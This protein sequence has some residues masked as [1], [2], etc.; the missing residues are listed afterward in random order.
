MEASIG[1][2][3]WGYIWRLIVWALL[4][5]FVFGFIFSFILSA[6]SRI[7]FYSSPESII[8]YYKKDLIGMLIIS[9]I[10]TVIACKFATSG[11]QKKF[12][13][14]SDNA[15]QVFKRIV[16][17][18]IIFTVIYIIY[19]LTNI[20]NIKKSIESLNS[21]SI[22]TQLLESF[23]KFG[24]TFSVISVILNSLVMVLMIPFEKKLLKIQ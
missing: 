24:T 1:K 13:I 22:N 11:I 8:S 19:S 10:V 18:L 9:L 20:S 23:G 21:L 7:S 3:T 2:I 16:I 14:N 5:A 12:T 15:R 17:V 4:T 6:T